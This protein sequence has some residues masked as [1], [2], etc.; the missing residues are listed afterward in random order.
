[1]CIDRKIYF[2]YLLVHM[3]YVIDFLGVDFVLPMYHRTQAHL[4]TIMVKTAKFIIGV[5]LFSVA[6][7]FTFHEEEE[8]KAVVLVLLRQT[9]SMRC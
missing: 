7:A 3:F 6:N 1:M 4:L 9:C 5:G 2:F 8:V